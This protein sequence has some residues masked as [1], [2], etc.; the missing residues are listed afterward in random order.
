MPPLWCTRY[1]AIVF[2]LSSLA[3]ALPAAANPPTKERVP[4]TMSGAGCDSKEPEMNR[5]LEGIPGVIGVY[6]NRLP[7]HILVDINPGTVKSSE[8]INRV[9]EAASSWQC[10]VEFIEG[11]ISATMPAASAAPPQHE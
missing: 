6:F 5:I 11:C 8:V 1:V 7:N 3:L 4:L 10:K 9:N 2:A